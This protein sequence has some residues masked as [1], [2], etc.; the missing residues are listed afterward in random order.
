MVHGYV[1]AGLRRADGFDR[2][3]LIHQKMWLHRRSPLSAL[4]LAMRDLGPTTL[5]P[6]TAADHPAVLRMIERLEGVDQAAIAARW[7][8]AM[9]RQLQ[10]MR[11]EDEVA[12]YA[13]NIVWPADPSLCDADP[14][15]RAILDHVATTSPVRP[16]EEIWI[17][18]FVG[19]RSGDQRDPLVVTAAATAAT[20]EWVTR[21][22]AWSFVPAVDAE[23]W[24]P[25][26][27][28]LAFTHRFDLGGA[29]RTHSVYGL[30][31][32]R[33]PVDAWLD[34][35]DERELTGESGPPPA[36]LLKPP[37]L[38]RAGFDDAVRA[39]L[40]DWRR[41][42]RLRANALMG[43]VL[44]GGLDAVDV[45]GLQA[46]LS[47]AIDRLGREP[48]GDRLVRV[49]D[50]TYRH[51]V[52]SQEAAA[53]VLGLP[54]S[55]YRRHLARAIERLTDLLWAVEIGELRR[56]ELVEELSND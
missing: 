16:G 24:G 5:G 48:R 2:Q 30:D 4:Y 37:P 31:W 55:T 21:P 18:R 15:V 27:D 33:L 41:A 46:S 36:T 56:D 53:E 22:L 6:G 39:A 40:R 42:D 50:R 23:F 35:L 45:E 51:A 8:A 43:S 14:V 29:V 52:P 20:V 19:G 28:Y 17:G 34:V 54:F 38:D 13:Y 25:A 10:V 47:G 32:R 49:L 3:L 44:A 11:I 9:P 7:L 12:A 26:M 1:V